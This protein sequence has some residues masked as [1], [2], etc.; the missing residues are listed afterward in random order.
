MKRISGFIIAALL[1]AAV[2]PERAQAFSFPP[3]VSDFE[4]ADCEGTFIPSVLFTT[5]GTPDIRISVINSTTGL[6]FG[7]VPHIGAPSA[8]GPTIFHSH[9]D[10]GTPC[11]GSCVDISGKSNAGTVVGG[12]T[13]AAGPNS[14]FNE[15]LSFTGGGQEITIPIS[16]TMS[17]ATDQVT[18]EKRSSYLQ[19]IEH[20]CPVHLDQNIFRQIIIKIHP[21]RALQQVAVQ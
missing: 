19:G 7:R 5:T 11:G 10:G 20:T 4:I 21:S 18:I 8:L 14:D 1:T 2:L 9:L 16:P 17:N 12:I 3:S 13:T 6:R 15:A